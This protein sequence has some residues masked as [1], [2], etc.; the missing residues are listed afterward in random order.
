[1]FVL[2]NTALMTS[3]Q[4]E[5]LIKLDSKPQPQITNKKIKKRISMDRNVLLFLYVINTV[6]LTITGVLFM[7]FVGDEEDI[8]FMYDLYRKIFI[9]STIIPTIIT[10]VYILCFG[11]GLIRTLYLYIRVVYTYKL[12]FT[13][14][15]NRIFEEL[16]NFD[17][18]I[19][20]DTIYESIK[21]IYLDF[22]KLKR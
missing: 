16:F 19:N 9:G 3:H 10:V 22:I 1:M 15:N 18:H 5:L 2:T 4:I 8:I 7:P 21:A 6:L 13:Y 14:L 20:Q 12:H 11:Y 17:Q